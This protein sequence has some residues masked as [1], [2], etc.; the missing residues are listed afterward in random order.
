MLT[1]K[2][3][4]KTSKIEGLGLFAD[5]RIP[6]GTTVWKFDARFDIFFDPEEVKNMAPIQKALVEKFAYLSTETGKYVY[7]IDDSRFMNHSSVNNNLD[8][9]LFPDELETRGVANRDIEIG[10]EILINYRNFDSADAKSE[11]AYLKR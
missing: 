6:K 10:E 8:V 3:S 1:I 7:C 4:V 11:E 9:V 5:E 2:A